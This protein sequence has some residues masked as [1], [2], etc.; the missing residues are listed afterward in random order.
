MVVATTASE[1]PSVSARVEA[2][3]IRC[4]MRDLS[5]RREEMS[6]RRGTNEEAAAAT[7]DRMSESTEPLDDT[8]NERGGSLR[9]P[10][11][12]LFHARRLGHFPHRAPLGEDRPATPG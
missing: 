4:T 3:R 7:Y 1:A 12:A 2:R 8:G 11:R 5:W 6:H 9:D 10:N